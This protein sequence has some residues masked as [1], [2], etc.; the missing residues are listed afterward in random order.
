MRAER[1]FVAFVGLVYQTVSLEFIFP[2]ERGWTVI[3]F[4]RPLIAVS[5]KMH[6]KVV[7]HLEGFLADVTF[8]LTWKKSQIIYANSVHLSA[9]WENTALIQ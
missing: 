7:L 5:E 6:L 9:L 8:I 3:T 4:K 2:V 1:A